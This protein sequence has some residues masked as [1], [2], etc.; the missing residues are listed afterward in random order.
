M[1]GSKSLERGWNII[2]H[3]DWDMSSATPGRTAPERIAPQAATARQALFLATGDGSCRRPGGRIEKEAVWSTRHGNKCSAGEL[4]LAP[5][6]CLVVL[7]ATFLATEPSMPESR[8]QNSDFTRASSDAK[9]QTSNAAREAS[10]AAQ[11]LHDQARDSAGRVADA[12]SKAAGNTAGSLED[13]LRRTIETQPFTALAIALGIGWLFG[14][15]H[16]P[17]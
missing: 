16:R 2:S 13:A 14:R 7:F 15:M 8:S 6:R 1:R 4:L 3:P 17:I 12:T 9:R 11:D 10:E 5:A